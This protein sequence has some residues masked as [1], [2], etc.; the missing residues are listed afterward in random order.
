M[1]TLFVSDLHLHPSRPHTARLFHDFLAGP[2]RGTAALYILGD[3]FDAWAGDDDLDDPFN[4]AVCADLKSLAD[5]GV[6]VFFLPGNRDFLIGSRFAAAAGL[7]LLTDETVVD[8]GGT[9]TLLLHGDT[10]CTE[11]REYQAFR[12][13]I[14]TDEWRRDFLAEPL[15]TRKAEIERLRSRS[16]NEKR[17]KPMALMDVSA[18]AVEQEFAGRR[19]TRMIHGHTHRMARHEHRPQGAACERWVLPEWDHGGGALA[20]DET[21]CRW[22]ALTP[23]TS[24]I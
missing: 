22:L 24:P 21:G 20:C 17:I 9:P 12:S 8:I 11:D 2:A 19:V 13:A 7:A 15:S 3:L 1:L 23:Q 4:A 6:A 18:T 5:S 16:E 10:L 14:R